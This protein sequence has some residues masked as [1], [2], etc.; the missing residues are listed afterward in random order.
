MVMQIKFM[1]KAIVSETFFVCMRSFD[2]KRYALFG[3]FV[4]K[5][6]V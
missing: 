2:K 4:S 6:D 5:V 3:V 1:L